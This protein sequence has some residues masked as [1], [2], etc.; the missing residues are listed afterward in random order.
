[1]GRVV[2]NVQSL[3]GNIGPPPYE[4]ETGETYRRKANDLNCP[5]IFFVFDFLFLVCFY[6]L[7]SC[8][9]FLSAAPRYATP[10]HTGRTEGS[11]ML[12]TVYYY[13]SILGRDE[14]EDNRW[15]GEMSRS[16]MILGSSFAYNSR[17]CFLGFWCAFLTLNF[18][19]LAYLLNCCYYLRCDIN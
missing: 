18:W 15:I 8:P 13:R 11:Y 9:F 4:P 12:V 14:Q 3:K 5:A 16:F 6:L 19:F 17:P 1:M 10:R 2:L 7:P